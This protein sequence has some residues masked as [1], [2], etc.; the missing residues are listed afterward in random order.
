MEWMNGDLTDA[1]VV[2]RFGAVWLVWFRRLRDE[3]EDKVKKELSHHVF[4]EREGR[5]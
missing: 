4:W 5:N 3:G 1:R 2:E